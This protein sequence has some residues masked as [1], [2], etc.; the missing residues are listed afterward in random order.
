MPY[1]KIASGD[2]T[3][4]P[5]LLQAARLRRAMI[6]SSGMATLGE[7]EAA[8]GVIAFG[9][10]CT[11]EPA[12]RRDFEAAF[13]SDAGQEMLQRHVTLMHCVTQYPAPA[14]AVNLR[15]M[16][17]MR[18]AFGLLVGY[19]DH[20]LGTE[21][22]IAAVARGATVV[23]KHFTLDRS[24]PGPDQAASLEPTELATLVKTIR[25]VESALGS[26]LKIPVPAELP[27][28]SVARRSLVASRQIKKGETLVVDALAAKRPG[29]GVSPMGLWD[30]VGRSAQRDYDIDDLIDP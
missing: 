16:D 10:T 15:A 1:L 9:L 8:L 20:T 23:E 22:A 24:L 19:S 27:N 14:C 29:L 2:I 6:V 3:A 11:R 26:P 18:A 17:T 28:R 4:A 30:M 25:S 7:I 12:G 21:V 5:L 13:A